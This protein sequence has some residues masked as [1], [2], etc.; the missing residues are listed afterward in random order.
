M[1]EKKVSGILLTLLLVGMS[2][3]AFKI[4]L[5]SAIVPKYPAVYVDPPI[6]EN[7]R[8]GNNVTVSINTDYTGLISAYQFTLSYNASILHG[9]SV[10]NGDI[11]T[12]DKTPLVLFIPGTFDNAEGT[13]SLT[14]AFIFIFVGP[15]PSVWGPGTLVEVAFMV[16]GYGT[17]DITLGP[18]TRLLGWPPD[19]WLEPAI[20]IDAESMPDHIGHGFFSNIIPGD[21]DGDEYVGSADAGMLN[22]AYGTSSGHQLYVAEADFDDDGYIGSADASIL[23]GNYGQSA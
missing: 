18:E 13:L 7:I 6:V 16:V 9:I 2:T 10:T 3:L 5:G 11:V 15:I 20:L 17:S 8:P 22:G 21:V 19:P 4:E 1:R 14:A 12:T 23:N